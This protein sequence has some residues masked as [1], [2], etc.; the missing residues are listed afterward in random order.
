[1]SPRYS[2]SG[3]ASGSKVPKINP[4][5]VAMP[6]DALEITARIKRPPMVGANERL[7]VAGVDATEFVATVP[8]RI[9]KSVNRAVAVAAYDHRF[10]AHENVYEVVGLADLGFMREIEPAAREDVLA[11]DLI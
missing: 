10:F 11:L 3:G 5:E 6:R 8:A 9:D 1:M 2:S 4:R 7:R